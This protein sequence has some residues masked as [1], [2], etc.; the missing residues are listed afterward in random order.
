LSC[1]AA[2]IAAPSTQAG[3]ESQV[4]KPAAVA[5]T[6]ASAPD[7]EPIIPRFSV[8]YIDKSVLPSKDFYRFANGTWLKNNPVPAD[9]ARWGSFSELAER[10]NFSFTPFLKVRAQTARLQPERP[11]EK[12]ATF[13]HRQW[14]QPN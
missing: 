12:L 11:S 14:I 13:L 9:K 10:N 2:L 7:K 6:S 1:A 4:S 3:L 5:A 8:E